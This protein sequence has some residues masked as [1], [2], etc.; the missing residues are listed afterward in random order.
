MVEIAL[1]GKKKKILQIIFGLA[2]FFS[3]ICM[4][5]VVQ[6]FIY[7]FLFVKILHVSGE[8]EYW[9]QIL[10]HIS[11]IST[12]LLSICFF[13]VYKSETIKIKS[14]NIFASAIL[15]SFALAQIVMIFDRWNMGINDS[16]YDFGDFFTAA[17]CSIQ[18]GEDICPPVS[19][20][21]YQIARNTF[22]GLNG[23]PWA[24]YSTMI[25]SFVAGYYIQLF[26]IFS[27]SPLAILIYKNINGTGLQKAFFAV[28]IFLSRPFMIGFQRG[29][30]VMQALI[31]LMVFVMC[32]KSK[33]SF[34]KE[35]ALLALALA[36]CFKI[37]T[38]VFG[39]LLLKEKDFKSAV[40]CAIYALAFFV[41]PVF[42][43]TTGV[44]SMI[45][46]IKALF[47]YVSSTTLGSQ[48]SIGGML[49]VFC[50][51]LGIENAYSVMFPIAMLVFVAF[52]AFIIIKSKKNWQIYFACC[53]A[54]VMI[55]T[56][57][58]PYTAIYFLIALIAIFNSQNKG[59][60]EYFVLACFLFLYTFN[61]YK[62]C[63]LTEIIFSVSSWGIYLLIAFIAV[64]VD[65]FLQNRKSHTLSVQK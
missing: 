57:S 16:R 36:F 41:L 3:F 26:F 53:A 50:K 56:L 6:K 21:I 64:V 27:L 65:C 24:D 9:R 32:Y 44:E 60:N 48:L 12:L 28:A 4:L 17:S 38:A 52:C 49:K 30:S 10:L 59:W 29:N 51:N 47:G 33:D 37:Y 62:L 5:T 63:K 34:I 23:N 25:D 58:W 20:L 14:S 46:Y 61:Y 11:F 35:I 43:H 45:L 7:N 40:R 18:M 1:N 8:F 19:M 13:I 22:P 39:V 15:L 2:L 31:C 42:C 55:P 54:C